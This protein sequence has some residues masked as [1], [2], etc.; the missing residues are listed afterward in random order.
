ML[1][2]NPQLANEWNYEKNG[3]MLPSNVTVFSGKKVWW[4]F[5]N[6][7]EKA[8]SF[9]DIDVTSIRRACRGEKAEYKGFVWKYKE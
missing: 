2:R 9:L 7:M 6:R 4:R 1:T 5:D 8:A 3:D